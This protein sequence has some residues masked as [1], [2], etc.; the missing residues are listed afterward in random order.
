MAQEQ[1]QINGVDMEAYED[2]KRLCPPKVLLADK[3]GQNWLKTA[4]NPHTP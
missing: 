2:F 4:F 3:N 1:Q